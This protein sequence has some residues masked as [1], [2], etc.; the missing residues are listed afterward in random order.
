[1]YITVGMLHQT[2]R[3]KKVVHCNGSICGN[4]E[5]TTLLIVFA[6]VDD[7]VDWSCSS[8]II[9]CASCTTGACFPSSILPS[10]PIDALVAPVIVTSSIA[11]YDPVHSNSP[12]SSC[13]SS[14]RRGMD[15]RFSSFHVHDS[16]EM[17]QACNAK[18]FTEELVGFRTSLPEEIAKF[19][20]A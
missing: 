20:V 3:Q 17:R 19:Q 8:V 13:I 12:T 4:I 6:F 1:M 5:L 10:S 16:K 2:E 7:F 14:L 18:Y 11:L 15:G 9:C